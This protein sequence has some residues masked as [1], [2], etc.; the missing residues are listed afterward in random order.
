MCV[1]LLHFQTPI[2]RGTSA[3]GTALQAG[4]YLG[5]ADDLEVRLA[6]HR[7]GNGAR[8]TEVIAQRGISFVVARVWPGADRHFERRLKKHNHGPR[9]CP[10]C[11]PHAAARGNYKEKP[12][13]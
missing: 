13:C 8:L 3:R 1:Y 7:A 6:Q 5:Y 4:H 9:L 12:S 11:N 2:S 10:I